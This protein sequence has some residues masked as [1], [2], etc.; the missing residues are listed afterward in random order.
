MVV[1]AIYDNYINMQT[2]KIIE[3]YDYSKLPSDQKK[4]YILL[5]EYDLAKRIE[6]LNDYFDENPELK[7]RPFYGEKIKDIGVEFDIIFR[8]CE[9]RDFIEN[10]DGTYSLG[11]VQG[12]KFDDYYDF[13]EKKKLGM[14]KKW[15]ISN[16]FDYYY[17]D[18]YYDS[19]DY[20]KE[21]LKKLHNNDRFDYY[22]TKWDESHKDKYVDKEL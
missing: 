6:F 13:G 15:C 19:D 14:I 9:Y 4:N 10:E 17:K 12:A 3:D 20:R 18:P 11:E 16:H 1:V 21:A 5:V 8:F 22:D 7:N 2:F